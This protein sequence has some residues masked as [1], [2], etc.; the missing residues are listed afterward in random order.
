MSAA[1]LR[2]AREEQMTDKELNE[3]REVVLAKRKKIMEELGLFQ[4]GMEEDVDSRD[5]RYSTHM[6]DEGSDTMERE[7]AYLLAAKE[8]K[9]LASLNNALERIESGEYGAC[10]ECHT[11]IPRERLE[12]VPNTRLCIACKTK[13]EK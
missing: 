13:L 3:F 11:D 5:N 12:A 7:Q 6:A 1:G 10:M 2:V 9:Y 4:K 8:N